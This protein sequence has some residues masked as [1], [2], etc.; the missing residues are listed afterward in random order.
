MKSPTYEGGGLGFC[1]AV[2]KKAWYEGGL[3]IKDFSILRD[4]I[5]DELLIFNG[6]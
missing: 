5:Y 1:K 3:D 4:G 2:I 6:A